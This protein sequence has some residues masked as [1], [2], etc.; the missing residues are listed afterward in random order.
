MLDYISLVVE[1]W[2]SMLRSVIS[3]ILLNI[4]CGLNYV[5]EDT[6][7]LIQTCTHNC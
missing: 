1:D 3:K 7:N 5:M 6:V 4:T 2:E